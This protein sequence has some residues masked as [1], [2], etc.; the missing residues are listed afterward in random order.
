MAMKRDPKQLVEQGYDHIAARYLAWNVPSL[1]RTTY[2]QNIL[3]R[4]LQGAEVPP[5][6]DVARGCHA[7]V[8]C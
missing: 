8:S 1:A 3:D 5:N 6:S 7:P 4:L 2:W